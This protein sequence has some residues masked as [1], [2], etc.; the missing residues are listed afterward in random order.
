MAFK[1]KGYSPF[2]QGLKRTLTRGLK[3]KEYTPQTIKPPKE[4]T[5]Q[6]VIDKFK[7]KLS[8][9]FSKGFMELAEE[10]VANI[11]GSAMKQNDNKEARLEKKVAVK[12]KKKPNL[13]NMTTDQIV[14]EMQN[15][16]QNNQSDFDRFNAYKNEV[17]KRNPDYDWG[18]NVDEVD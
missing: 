11:A 17:L 13:K 10:G 5:P 14:S 18:M 3:T 7:N 8:K 1:M 12:I 16:P 15:M 6:T 2:T 9:S 4:L